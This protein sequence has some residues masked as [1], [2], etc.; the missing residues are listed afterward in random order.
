MS[1]MMRRRLTISLL[2]LV[3]AGLLLGL[4]AI[5]RPD[6]RDRLA[7]RLTGSAPEP[8]PVLLIVVGHR[9]HVSALRDSLPDAVVVQASDEAFALESG[10]IFASRIEAASELLNALGW[11]DR[12][13]AIFDPRR[14]PGGLPSVPSGS[15]SVL[16]PRTNPADGASLA[17][18]A[19]RDT[20]TLD[21]AMQALRMLR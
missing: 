9:E 19:R 8:E 11:G 4:T 20:L 2:L 17:E 16:D 1:S 12:P 6:L 5:A 7:N 21:E 13:L 3:I 18:L 10:R 15:S 14:G